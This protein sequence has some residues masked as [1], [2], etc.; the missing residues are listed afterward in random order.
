[1]RLAF[2]RDWTRLVVSYVEDNKVTSPLPSIFNIGA[3]YYPK[4]YTSN[5]FIN[6]DYFHMNHILG[7][8]SAILQSS[9]RLTALPIDQLTYSYEVL[10]RMESRPVLSRAD[11]SS[12]TNS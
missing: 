2:F 5:R 7:L 9:A 3:F 1:M 11:V 8:F 4:G 10:D 6:D 12:A